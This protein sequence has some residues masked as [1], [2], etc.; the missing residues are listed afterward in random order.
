[1]HRSFL[2][3]AAVAALLA[4]GAYP[5]LAARPAPTRGAITDATGDWAVASQDILSAQVTSGR[6]NG[7]PTVRAVLTLADAPDGV[8]QYAVSFAS[9]CDSWVLSARGIG[10]GDM[11]DVR[12]QHSVCRPAAQFA[13]SAPENAPAQV[14]V[15]GKQVVLTAKYA[16]GLEKGLRV[17]SMAASA[18]PF[19]TGA[20]VGQDAVGQDGWV[21]SGDLAL[22]NVRFELT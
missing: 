14:A 2:A 1:V 17:T 9:G 13:T 8:A 11:Q 21:T 10:G 22:A 6:V 18:S 4:S 12:L 16:L 5:A 19:F 3:A 7:V 20:T 15:S